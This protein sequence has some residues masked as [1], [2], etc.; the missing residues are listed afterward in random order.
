MNE[1]EYIPETPDELTAQWL[2][3]VLTDNGVIQGGRISEVTAKD[4]GEGVGFLG[5]ILR[6]QLTYDHESATGPQSVIAKLPKLANRPMGEMLGAY[7]RETLFYLDHASRMPCRIPALYY[8]AFDRD[9]SSE[10]QE[11][12]LKFI[13]RL[14]RF[15]NGAI[16][17]LGLKVAAG[18]KRRYALLIEDIN[19]G[20]AG[21]QVAGATEHQC[22]Q[23]LRS[24]AR[25]QARFWH[26]QGLDSH[27]WL[28][29]LGID[30]RL[31]HH[32]FSRARTNFESTFADLV[33]GGLGAHLDRV[34]ANG[35]EFANRLSEA[36][37]T[38]LHCDLRLDNV[39]FAADEA[40][41]LDWQLVR[42]GAGAYDV[43]YLLGGALDANLGPAD[44]EAFLQFYYRSLTQHGVSGYSF[45]D[46]ANHYRLSLYLILQ[47]LSTTDQV[48]LGED[49]GVRMIRSW[50]ERLFRRLENAEV[51]VR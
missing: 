16:T 25:T 28:L 45:H 26:G 23:V 22:Q 40:V 17:Q 30:R 43:A 3:E 27:F 49:R 5:D 14:P 34:A 48:E 10:Q 39:I 13:D 35:I 32:M 6:L 41:I 42:H 51:F 47:T 31:R 38:L 50:I 9:K 44:D 33:A 12:I 11:Q 4:I 7:E 1:P 29:P 20:T 24:I 2:T 15:M 21:D 46:F 19:D 18:K 36:P 8:G 37:D